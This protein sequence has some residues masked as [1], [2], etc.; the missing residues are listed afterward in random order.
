MIRRCFECHHLYLPAFQAQA[1]VRVDNGVVRR[2][3]HGHARCLVR[4][5]ADVALAGRERSTR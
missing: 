3:V 2:K 1:V 4:A 5:F